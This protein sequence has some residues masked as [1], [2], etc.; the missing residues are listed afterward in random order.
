MPSPPRRRRALV[1]AAARWATFGSPCPCSKARAAEARCSISRPSVVTA[2]RG[3]FRR[4]RRAA[5]Q[6][7]AHRETRATRATWTAR[8]RF[9]TGSSRWT[10]SGARATLALSGRRAA[11]RQAAREAEQERAAEAAARDADAGCRA[12]ANAAGSTP[13]AG[14]CRAKDA[15]ALRG[16]PRGRYEEENGRRDSGIRRTRRCFFPSK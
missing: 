11:E 16:R 15:R 12:A 6:S 7:G 13:C 10:P 4:A 3:G 8:W 5:T 14:R 2:E 9:S 1:A